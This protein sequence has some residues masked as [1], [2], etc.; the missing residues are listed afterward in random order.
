MEISKRKCLWIFH[1]RFIIN[2][3][4][5]LPVKGSTL[6]PQQSPRAWFEKFTNSVRRYGYKQ[7]HADHTLFFRRCEGKISILIVYVDDIVLTGDDIVELMNI[8]RKLSLD[9][10]MKDL[11]PQIRSWHGNSHK[12]NRDFSFTEEIHT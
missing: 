3:W 8:K 4:K 10:E 5:G 7:S 1:I 9:F 12:Q 6:W 2:K 11:G